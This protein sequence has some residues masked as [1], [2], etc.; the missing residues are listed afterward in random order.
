VTDGDLF[1]R[2]SALR[3]SATVE[4][5][6]ASTGGHVIG[7]GWATVE[8][9]RAILELSAGL[10][11]A[12]DHFADATASVGLG[13]TCLVARSVLA[14]GVSLVL[15]EP[16]TEGRLAGTLARHGEGPVAVWLAIDGRAD[17]SPALGTAPPTSRAL[18]GPF[19]LERLILGPIHG[20]HLFL[21]ERPG[22]I[23]A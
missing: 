13:A 6:A 23:R 11:I 22:T 5:A 16:N 21:I 8:L 2:L 15:V 9:D 1:A 4:D 3:E 12:A 20:P 14:G 7:V 19:G 18:A 17:S 10:G